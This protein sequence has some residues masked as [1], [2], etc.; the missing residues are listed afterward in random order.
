MASLKGLPPRKL[1]RTH[2]ERD[3]LG[4]AVGVSRHRNS[5]V[6]RGIGPVERALAGGALLGSGDRWDFDHRGNRPRNRAG[7][8]HFR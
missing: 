5:Y 7:I 4:G 6:E 1:P 8:A 2:G 3:A